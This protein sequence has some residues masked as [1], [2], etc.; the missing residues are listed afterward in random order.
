MRYPPPESDIN[1]A[2]NGPFWVEVANP[3]HPF[4]A[5][6]ISRSRGTCLI[7]HL[8]SANLLPKPMYETSWANER[9]S[10]KLFPSASLL[11]PVLSVHAPCSVHSCSAV[12]S[13]EM[14]EGRWRPYLRPT[15]GYYGL[16]ERLL[17]VELYCQ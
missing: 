4:T 15:R 14:N 16:N 17:S 7:A 2:V 5:M 1:I 9:A 12:S 10:Q 8:F 13:L 11:P 3:E 6:L